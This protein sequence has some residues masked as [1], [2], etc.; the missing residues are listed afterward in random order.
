MNSFESIVK[1]TEVVLE[2]AR[3]LRRLGLMDDKRF[4]LPSLEDLNKIKNRLNDIQPIHITASILGDGDREKNKH[5]YYEHLRP[6]LM[7]YPAFGVGGIVIDG[8]FHYIIDGLEYKLRGKSDEEQYKYY[9]EIWEINDKLHDILKGM[10]GD[11]KYIFGEPVV[12]WSIYE[13]SVSFEDTP[14]ENPS[15][16]P[17]S[18]AKELPQELDTPEIVAVMD[19]AIDRGLMSEKGD[20]FE[21]KDLLCIFCAR[22]FATYMVK[23]N[24]DLN[25]DGSLK[26]YWKPFEEYFK[27]KRN[28]IKPES[29]KITYNKSKTYNPK[30][31]FL[32]DEVISQ[33]SN[34]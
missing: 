15:I 34:L 20:W 18:R 6:Y 10:N 33:P 5:Y 11:I 19:K 16:N 17:S 12:D 32:I 29:M 2:T 27:I 3:T 26:L 1:F 25:P 21:K 14:E 8:E 9:D 23:P 4:P 7:I 30:K 28:P 31:L 22:I 24:P 13:H